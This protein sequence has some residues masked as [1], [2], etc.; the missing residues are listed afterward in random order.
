MGFFALVDQYIWDF[1]YIYNRP[2]G[3]RAGREADVA[4]FG[5]KFSCPWDECSYSLASY[6]AAE[7]FVKICP[8]CGRPIWWAKEGTEP[9]RADERQPNG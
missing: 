4:H 6:W 5:W 7:N 3:R 1:L 8:A 9:R 2:F